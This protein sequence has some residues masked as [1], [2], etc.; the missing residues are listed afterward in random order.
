MPNIRFVQAL[1]VTILFLSVGTAL[2]QNQQTYMLMSEGLVRVNGVPVPRSTVVFPGDIVET[3]NGA[4]ARISAPGRSMLV[5]ESSRVSVDGGLVV[6]SGAAAP[7]VASSS[8]VPPLTFDQLS[9]TPISNVCRTA[10]ECVLQDCETLPLPCRERLRKPVDG[11]GTR[12]S[13]PDVTAKA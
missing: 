1:A 10:R 8:A 11:T 4:A 7:P 13:V 12:R 2:A 3:S 5:P 6:N 9:D